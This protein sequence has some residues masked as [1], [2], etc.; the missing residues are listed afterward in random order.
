MPGF[1]RSGPMGEGPLT[2]GGRGRC[3]PTNRQYAPQL[4]RGYAPR[5]LGLR[6]GFR[7]GAGNAGA[8]RG[9]AAMAGGWPQ[10]FAPGYPIDPPDELDTLRQEADYLKTSLDAINRRIDMLEKKKTLSKLRL[11]KNGEGRYLIT[12]PS[13][14]YFA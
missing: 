14:K 3:N 6:R 5:G 2:G 4:R 9:F 10:A 7:G 1:D 13:I 11:V 12:A 8:G